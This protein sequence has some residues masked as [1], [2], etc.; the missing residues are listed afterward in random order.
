VKAKSL[1]LRDTFGFST[2]NLNKAIAAERLR[3]LMG[4]SCALMARRASGNL[5]K[6]TRPIRTA[7]RARKSL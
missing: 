5:M 2:G 1:L 3:A 7:V 6:P 4:R